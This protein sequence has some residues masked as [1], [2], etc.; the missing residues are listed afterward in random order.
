[1]L[2]DN[3]V[4]E[5]DAVA[6]EVC[7]ST[8]RRPGPENAS[9]SEDGGRGGKLAAALLLGARG[10][11]F[12]GSE[13]VDDGSALTESGNNSTRLDGREIVSVDPPLHNSAEEDLAG[14]SPAAF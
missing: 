14:S 10:G 2:T 7:T 3:V 12:L 4:E 1:M 9:R 5:R 6:A 11:K 8:P 13:L